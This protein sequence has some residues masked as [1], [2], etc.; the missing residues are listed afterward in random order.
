[1]T[2]IDIWFILLTNVNIFLHKISEYLS[3]KRPMS[4]QFQLIEFIIDSNLTSI[5]NFINLNRDDYYFLSVCPIFQRMSDNQ[6]L[7]AI[8]FVIFTKHFLEK[9]INKDSKKIVCI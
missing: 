8:F 3:L 9:L 1:M 4:I 7:N 6:E 2:T 5:P